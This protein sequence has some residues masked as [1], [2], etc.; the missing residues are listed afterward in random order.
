MFFITVS[1]MES[2]KNNLIFDLQNYKV[3]LLI[4]K[5]VEHKNNTSKI[6]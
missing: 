5:L 3:T 1:F 4:S 6:T 2:I